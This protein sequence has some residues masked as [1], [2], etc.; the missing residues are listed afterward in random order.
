MQ[1]FGVKKEWRKDRC[2]VLKCHYKS[3]FCVIVRFYQTR[4]LMPTAVECLM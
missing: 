1:T 2:S 4:E 3:V